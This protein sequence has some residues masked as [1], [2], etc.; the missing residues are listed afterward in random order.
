MKPERQIRARM[1]KCVDEEIERRFAEATRRLPRRCKHHIEHALDTRAEVN[2][3]PNPLF[4]RVGSAVHLPVLGLCGYGMGSEEWGGTICEDPIDA[5]R[6]PLFEARQSKEDLIRDLDNELSH[7]LWVEENMP[8]LAAL[9]WVLEANP[10]HPMT[11]WQRFRLLFRKVSVEPVLTPTEAVTK[12]LG[13]SSDESV[14]KD[15]LTDLYTKDDSDVLST[16]KD[17]GP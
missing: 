15:L 6:C 2:S 10:N 14:A 5:Q 13:T 16:P 17:L 3:E 4:N 9:R 11:W 8:E 1:K 12:V 7:K